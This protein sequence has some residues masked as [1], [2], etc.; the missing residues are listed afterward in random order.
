MFERIWDY[1]QGFAGILS[2]ISVYAMALGMIPVL[3]GQPHTIALPVWILSAAVQLLL[4]CILIS[5]GTS[6]SIYLVVHAAVMAAETYLTV[7]ASIFPAYEAELR[8]LLIIGLLLVGAHIALAAWRLP[9]ANALL[10][11]VDVLIVVTAFYLYCAYGT[12]H[13]A[14]P[15][16]VGCA[17][18]ALVLN[19]IVTGHLRTGGEGGRVI[20]GAGAGS[21]LVLLL[22]LAACI[23]IT[24]AVVGVASGEIH[25]AMDLA[26]MIL[27][28]IMSVLSVIFGVL[29]KILAFVILLL[30]ALF[31]MASAPVK[32]NAVQQ[33]EN[34]MEEILPESGEMLDP[35]I[36]MA[37]T[38]ALLLA[39]I[40]WLLWRLKDIRI[41]RPERR[42]MTRQ[43]VRKSHFRSA[44]YELWKRVRDTVIFE[45]E[46]FRYRKTPQGI[47][48]LAQRLGRKHRIIR[49]RDESPGAYIR[50]LDAEKDLGL[51]ELASCLDAAFYEENAGNPEIFDYRAYVR[52]LKVLE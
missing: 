40:F 45:W 21:R 46:Y 28:G 32:E 27:K 17:A 24:G 39:G 23:G 8:C 16:E 19:L 52:K 50:R 42:K 12:G 51:Q 34:T 36:V 44:L 11:Y 49:R 31:P 38:G 4:A 25:S 2:D 37:V 33:L 7:R 47:F 15:G 41:Q 10:R 3:T 30:I 48:V 5:A 35:R 18:A 20:R 26:L 43:F 9:S 29:G 13:A 22:I 1:L 14:E 6:W